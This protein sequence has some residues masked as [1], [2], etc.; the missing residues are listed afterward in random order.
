MNSANWY[1][2]MS[3][4]ER[5]ECD[6]LLA[7]KGSVTMNFTPPIPAISTNDDSLPLVQAYVQ[8]AGPHTSVAVQSQ[9]GP[10]APVPSIKVDTKLCDAHKPIMFATGQ[11]WKHKYEFSWSN[12]GNMLPMHS[13]V[14]IV[15][16]TKYMVSFQVKSIED[17]ISWQFEEKPRRVKIYVSQH[18]QHEYL[19]AGASSIYSTS[20]MQLVKK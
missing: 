20:S 1:E 2:M 19:K 6:V 7:T 9:T 3:K 16:R 15:K 11:V 13:F 8:H 10:E 5:L 17:G 4:E 18:D 14:Y 12:F